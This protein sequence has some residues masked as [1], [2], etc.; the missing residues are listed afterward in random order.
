MRD[1]FQ[2]AKRRGETTTNTE[3]VDKIVEENSTVTLLGNR[4]LSTLVTKDI[5]IEGLNG[6][7]GY[8]TP[9]AGPAPWF[10]GHLRMLSNNCLGS[11]TTIDTFP[12]TRTDFWVCSPL[13]QEVQIAALFLSRF[14]MIVR[15]ILAISHSSKGLGSFHWDLLWSCWQDT[16]SAE[17]FIH[18]VDT[19]DHPTHDSLA[20]RF[21]SDGSTDDWPSLYVKSFLDELGK[22]FIVKFSPALDDMCILLHERDPGNI[23]YNPSMSAIYTKLFFLSKMVYLM[24]VT[25]LVAELSRP[26]TGHL[27]KGLKTLKRQID[28]R[29][30]LLG[31]MDAI[32]SIKREIKEK[33]VILFGARAIVHQRRRKADAGPDSARLARQ[34]KIR[35]AS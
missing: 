10:E 4:A 28:E 18:F 27:F 14:L 1:H 29:T 30:R 25:F 11:A 8:S 26:F 32:D 17:H 24:T 21:G 6:F 34:H 35:A 15:P 13:H 22:I 12:A 19:A 5:T 3:C 2:R 16:L 31:L 33:E 20:A 7:S 23:A 9:G